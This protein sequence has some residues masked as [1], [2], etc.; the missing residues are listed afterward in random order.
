MWVTWAVHWANSLAVAGILE[1]TTLGSLSLT[2]GAGYEEVNGAFT[3]DVKSMV[4]K[5]LG[6]I[7]GCTQC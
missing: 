2:W 7:L 1:I 3:L 6:G 5:N 4:N